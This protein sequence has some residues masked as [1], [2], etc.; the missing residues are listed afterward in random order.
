MGTRLGLHSLR[1]GSGEH[2]SRFSPSPEELVF[3]SVHR[4]EVINSSFKSLGLLLNFSI[5]LLALTHPRLVC[6]T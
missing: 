5:P 2:L 4:A 1:Q 6:E 3:G